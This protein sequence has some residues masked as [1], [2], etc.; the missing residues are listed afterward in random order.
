MSEN[1]DDFL[2]IYIDFENLALWA[3]DEN[4]SFKLSDLMRYF[5]NRGQLAIRRAYANWYYF[6]EYKYDMTLNSIDLVQVYSV[7]Q[8]KNRAD[9]RIVVDAL[10]AAFIHKHVNTF[11]IISGDSD[12]GPLASKLQSY[13]KKVI[14]VGP[15]GERSHKLF[16]RAC[17]EFISLENVLR[18]QPDKKQEQ[19]PEKHHNNKNN[20]SKKQERSGSETP[21]Q[22]SAPEPTAPPKAEPPAPVKL[23]VPAKPTIRLNPTD[24]PLGD[25]PALL[26]IWQDVV[27]LESANIAPTPQAATEEADNAMAARKKRN[28]EE[29]GDG[30]LHATRLLWDF[31]ADEPMGEHLQELRW[32]MASYAAIKAG[33][34][35]KQEAFADAHSY[36]LAFF[37]LVKDPE[38]RSRVDGLIKPMITYYWGSAFREHGER[39]P[40]GPKNRML[41]PAQMGDE[42]VKSKNQAIRNTWKAL[43]ARFA[44]VNKELLAEVIDDMKPQLK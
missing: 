3:Q 40:T 27:N 42:V 38:V 1:T 11:V 31:I 2:A 26:P 33:E 23:V 22:E 36:Y 30:F 9:I 39:M 28:Y 16:V 7:G 34:A 19:K 44:A 10:E 5:G 29:A 35:L 8:G 32:Y 20:S 12:F 37:A 6:D 14:G 43:T 15:P 4:V 17:N 21:K 41:M 25:M 13:G 24:L 18:V